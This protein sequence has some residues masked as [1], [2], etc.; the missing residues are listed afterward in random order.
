[1]PAA[2]RRLE[3]WV[4]ARYRRQV[5]TVRVPVDTNIDD[6]ALERLALAF[7]REYERLFGAGAA[8][9]E[10]G[11]ELIHY[12]VEAMGL[13][14]MPPAQAAAPAGTLVEPRTRRPT[15]CP[16]RRDMVAT[17]IYDG[18]SLPA[19]AAFAGPAIIDQ[20]GTTIVVHDGQQVRVDERGCIRI[21]I[22]PAPT[23]TAHG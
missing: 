6:K 4:E 7:A 1:M 3:R 19:G 23:G 13:A 22:G 14:D 5:H 10:A 21:A 16:R 12:G 8:L 15:Y 2:R 9:D 17:A 20:P 18:P 11:I